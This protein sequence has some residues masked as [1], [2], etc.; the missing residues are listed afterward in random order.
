M[1]TLFCG[2]QH[3]TAPHPALRK[4]AKND[5]WTLAILHSSLVMSCSSTTTPDVP[6]STASDSSAGIADG[7]GGSSGSSS[8]NA[9]SLNSLLSAGYALLQSGH[10][11]HGEMPSLTTSGAVATSGVVG[12]RHILSDDYRREFLRNTLEGAMRLMDEKADD[13]DHHLP[14]SP[15]SIAPSRTSEEEQGEEEEGEDG[16]G[17]GEVKDEEEDARPLPRP[18][19]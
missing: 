5:D 9:D 10:Q 14:S 3:R 11:Q 16:G 4:K 7:S 2:L 12:M 15:S 6:S 13:K 19:Q 17:S 8:N 1:H 18:E